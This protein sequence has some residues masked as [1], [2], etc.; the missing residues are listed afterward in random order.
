MPALSCAGTLNAPTISAYYNGSS[1]LTDDYSTE[2][3]AGWFLDG[4]VAFG[5]LPSA[6]A[7]GEQFLFFLF[8]LFF[9]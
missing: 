5:P 8:F 3:E 2:G 4:K 1:Y 7:A 6:L 9:L